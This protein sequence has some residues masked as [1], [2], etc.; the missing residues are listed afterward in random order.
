MEGTDKT[1]ESPNKRQNKTGEHLPDLSKLNMEVKDKENP[2]A[3][4]KSEPGKTTEMGLTGKADMFAKNA[5]YRWVECRTV[6]LPSWFNHSIM[7]RI[8]QHNSCVFELF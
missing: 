7:P 8:R 1:L 2:G 3:S 4:V 5:K 6:F